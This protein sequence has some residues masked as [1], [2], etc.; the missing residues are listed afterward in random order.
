MRTQRTTAKL[1]KH[2]LSHEKVAPVDLKE[3][4]KRKLI[5]LA[6]AQVKTLLML[7][8]Q[9]ELLETKS[10]TTFGQAKKVK[11][12]DK[13]EIRKALTFIRSISR[14]SKLQKLLLRKSCPTAL[15]YTSQS[16]C[17]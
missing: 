13:K 17:R 15:E 8:Q 12:N 11:M 3:S 4:Q 14:H 5:C 2:W 10:M 6:T 1:R 9:Q 16:E 7:H